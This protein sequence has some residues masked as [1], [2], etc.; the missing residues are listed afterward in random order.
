MSN[1]PILTSISGSNG[2]NDANPISKI[3]LLPYYCTLC[4]KLRI[5]TA[6]PFR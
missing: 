5:C 3:G 2:A 6:A 1:A 4:T